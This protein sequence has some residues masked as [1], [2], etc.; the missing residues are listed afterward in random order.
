MARSGQRRMVVLTGLKAGRICRY[1]KII[2]MFHGVGVASMA[3][4][5]IMVRIT[6]PARARGTFQL[7]FDLR[8]R[9][10]GLY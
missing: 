1:N 8:D 10:C 4:R 9:V 5:E 3:E 2:H 7:P 6:R